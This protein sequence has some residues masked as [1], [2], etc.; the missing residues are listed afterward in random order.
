MIQPDDYLT[1][2]WEYKVLTLCPTVP[3]IRTATPKKLINESFFIDSMAS[4]DDPQPWITLW[5]LL[6]AA[7]PQ[8][9][10]L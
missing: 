3:R 7:H 1:D 6:T 8:V 4:S 10:S 9:R 5:N 2:I